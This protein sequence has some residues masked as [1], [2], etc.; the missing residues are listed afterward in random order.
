MRLNETTRSVLREARRRSA[1]Q[2]AR[3]DTGDVRSAA[4]RLCPA[5][6]AE[7]ETVHY[8]SLL[9]ERLWCRDHVAG[10]A[11]RERDPF[12]GPKG[13]L[14]FGT[15]DED[16][17]GTHGRRCL[18]ASAD[19]AITIEPHGGPDV[20][21][22]HLPRSIRRMYRA[23]EQAALGVYPVRQAARPDERGDR[24]GAQLR[25]KGVCP[26]GSGPR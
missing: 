13:S 12:H 15:A 26:T 25:A 6:L 10:G 4:I 18:L 2:S 5:H 21:S 16:L 14:I 1:P 11:E 9:R 3:R 23:L 17:R 19:P 7:H 22:R 20:L 8:S 24:H